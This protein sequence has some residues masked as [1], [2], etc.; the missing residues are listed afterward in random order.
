MVAFFFIS[1]NGWI[2][3]FRQPL[4]MVMV[5]EDRFSGY[6]GKSDRSK[7][8]SSTVGKF[9]QSKGRGPDASLVKQRSGVRSL[10]PAELRAKERFTFSESDVERV[11][12]AE[13]RL[14]LSALSVGQKLRG[15]II[16]VKE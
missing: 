13:S 11:H 10:S 14:P 15:R 12:A 5:R 6:G 4:R 1:V 7:S 2:S 16:G 3:L 9:S 8:K